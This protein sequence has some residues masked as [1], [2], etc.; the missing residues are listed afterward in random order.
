MR[1]LK[2]AALAQWTFDGILDL[3]LRDASTDPRAEEL[4]KRFVFKLVP[5]VNPDGVARGGSGTAA[6]RLATTS[7]RL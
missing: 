6:A 2:W 1:A 4:R 3:L 5:M 7:T